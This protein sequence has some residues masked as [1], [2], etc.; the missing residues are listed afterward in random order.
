[1]FCWCCLFEGGV[2]EQGLVSPSEKI[3]GSRS[4]GGLCRLGTILEPDSED[5]DTDGSCGGRGWGG[6][7]FSVWSDR[8]KSSSSSDDSHSGGT[9]CSQPLGC[10]NPDSFFFCLYLPAAAAATR[11]LRAAPSRLPA[12]PFPR[13]HGPP[14]GGI[15]G[16]REPL[17]PLVQTRQAGLGAR[18]RGKGLLQLQDGAGL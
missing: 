15:G 11:R 18:E 13:L 14:P 10:C 16:G 5:V 3:T 8:L 6:S 2:P 17:L 4:G 9:S 1:M 12:L 7:I